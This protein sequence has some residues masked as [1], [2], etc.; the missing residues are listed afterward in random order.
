[1]QKI[2]LVVAMLLLALVIGFIGAF[3]TWTAD[4]ALAEPGCHLFS[5]TCD[6][7]YV[8]RMTGC[9]FAMLLAFGLLLM[10]ADK[11]KRSN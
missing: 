3:G 6:P 7:F 1:M 10:T 8:N 2:L 5:G 11:F 4:Y 9:G